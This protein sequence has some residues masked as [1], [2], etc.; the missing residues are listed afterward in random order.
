[1]VFHESIGCIWRGYVD[2]GKDVQ[3]RSIQYTLTLGWLLFCRHTGIQID[4]QHSVTHIFIIQ[5]E[6]I[7]LEQLSIKMDF[8]NIGDLVSITIWLFALEKSLSLYDLGEMHQIFF[9]LNVIFTTTN[10]IH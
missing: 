2:G 7:Q 3:I 6:L 5:Y 10:S 4:L 1:M 8:G 9:V